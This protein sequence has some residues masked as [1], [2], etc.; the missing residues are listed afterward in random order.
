MSHELGTP[1]PDWKPATVPP[2]DVMRGRHCQ[3]SPLTLNHAPQLWRAL[4][5]HPDLW[6]YLPD[7]PFASEADF[8]AWMSVQLRRDDAIFWAI[9]ND[10]GAPVGL[11]AYLRI[12]PDNGSI[13]IGNVLFSPA[14]QRT[15]AA[16]EA[17]FLL[18]RAVFER[19]FRRYE[20]K[21]NA[22]NAPSRAAAR[23]L[24]F[25]YEG[26]FRNAMIVKGRNRDTDW[27]SIT[28]EEWPARQSALEAWL[29][30]ENFDANGA[31]I[32]RLDALRASGK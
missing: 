4:A 17:M 11:C 27:F 7:G 6:R 10:A 15:R 13:E 29:A 20:W 18:M 25:S 12:D 2:R 5:D 26:T 19:G 9:E 22:L 31:Q 1:L 24:G 8:S 21:C 3:L 28:A 16:T 32:A 30:P 23:R 14:L